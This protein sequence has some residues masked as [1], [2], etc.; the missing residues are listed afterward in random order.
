MS[1]IETY[2]TAYSKEYNAALM[3]ALY[4]SEKTR[5]C[6]EPGHEWRRAQRAARPI[7]WKS[8]AMTYDEAKTLMCCIGSHETLAALF[9]SGALHEDY[10][11]RLLGEEWSRFKHMAD[12][13]SLLARCLQG[14]DTTDMMSRHERRALN[15]LPGTLT[16]YRGC[17]PKG[18]HGLSWT[19]SKEVAHWFAN[20]FSYDEPGL[21]ITA[22]VRKNRVF[23]LK[24]GRSEREIVVWKPRIVSVEKIQEDH[25]PFP[26]RGV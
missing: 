2:T 24:L 14:R 23:A 7:L 10:G 6:L 22:R 15:Q 17:G 12:Y 1:I 3:S 20:R 4:G 8:P 13:N 5:Q 21:L 9:D 26:K 16:I 19:L 11:M 25:K 18:K